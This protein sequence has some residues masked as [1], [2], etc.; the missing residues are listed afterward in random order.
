MGPRRGPGTSRT[1]LHR[2]AARQPRNAGTTPTGQMMGL[3]SARPRRR[4]RA[5]GAAL[6]DAIQLVAGVSIPWRPTMARR[7]LSEATGAATLRPPPGLVRG[8]CP[9][10]AIG[11]RSE[12]TRPDRAGRR[13]SDPSRRTSPAPTK[14]SQHAGLEHEMT[15]GVGGG[16]GQR[17]GSFIGGRSP[18]APRALA[19]SPAGSQTRGARRRWRRAPRCRVLGAVPRSS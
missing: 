14:R 19:A 18:D 7:L 2:R 13:K 8:P 17:R 1:L 11:G 3:V 12:G 15:V 9:R 10:V 6:G 5:D 16:R 4:R